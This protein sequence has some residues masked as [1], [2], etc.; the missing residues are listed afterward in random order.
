MRLLLSTLLLGLAWFAAVNLL[1]SALAWVVSRRVL[2]S[3]RAIPA[4]ALLSLRLLPA[5]AA[6][7]FVLV[8]FLP[9][10]VR[11]EPAQ[12]DE[13]FGLIV[14]A[15]ALAGC[16]LLARSVRRLWRIRTA[17]RQARGWTAVPVPSAVGEA[18]EVN[19]FSGVSLAGIVRTRILI[20]TAARA[21]LTTEELALAVAHEHAHR[22]SFDNLKRCV[23]FCAPDF[24]GWTAAA[25]HLER[26]WRGEAE[27]DADTRAVNG[28]DRR[29]V[30]L[31]SALLKVARLDAGREAVV[32]AP[33]WSPFNEPPL[34]EIR[35][36]AL[37]S[38]Q[39]SAPA[40]P[41]VRRGLAVALAACPVALSLLLAQAPPRVHQLTEALVAVLP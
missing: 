11:L 17:S 7:A 25:A 24:F 8:L 21:A 16:G 18:Y 32:P 36:R 38:G 1:T 29:A 5:G 20:G 19:G 14:A 2:A 13:R 34:L 22:V 31:A 15:L 3:G 23:M 26:R 33:V 9:A 39:A 40:G 6:A 35:I 28:D 41:R 10:H 27:C 30:H 37:V 12:S 4:A